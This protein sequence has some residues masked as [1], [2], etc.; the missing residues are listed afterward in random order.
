MISNFI[1]LPDRNREIGQLLMPMKR[2]DWI[3]SSQRPSFSPAEHGTRTRFRLTARSNKKIVWIGWFDDREDADVFLFNMANGY[4]KYDKKLWD[5]SLP[6]WRPDLGEDVTYEFATVTFITSG[7]TYTKPADWNN[8]VNTIDTV[9]GGGGGFTPTA[10]GGGGGGGGAHNTTSNVTLAGNAS[11]QVGASVSAGTVGGD[12]WFNGTTLALS[13]CGSKGGGAGTVSS[14]AA[15]GVGSSGIGTTSHNGGSGGNATTG[16]GAGGGGGAGG[17]HGVGGAGGANG[18]TANFGCGGGGNGGGSAG[19]TGSTS[20]GGNN[21]SGTGGGAVNSN[22]TSGGGG[23]GNGSGGAFAGAATG[24]GLDWDAT[25]GSGGG[26]GGGGNGTSKNGGNG[27]NYGG[28]GGGGGFSVSAGTGGI[29]TR[30]IIVVTYTPLIA[31]INGFN[32]AMM[33]M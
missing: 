3:E 15:G 19:A 11:I 7:A 16:V 22:G 4:L 21:Y 1:Y 29:G 12:T 9:G 32:L 14:V 31:S 27:G 5:L 8:G 2:L 28:G 25:H 23:G 17:P 30:G 10:H 33:G 20:V 24:S 26:G 13:S 6:A 18:G